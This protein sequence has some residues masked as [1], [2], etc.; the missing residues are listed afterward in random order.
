ML[1]RFS[2]ATY[3]G[4]ELPHN[5]SGNARLQSS[6]LLEPLWIAPRSGAR[7]L[8]STKEKIKKKKNTERTFTEKKKNLRT[9][10]KG[11]PLAVKAKCTS[12]SHRYHFDSLF[13]TSVTSYW[14]RTGG[15]MQLHEQRRQTINSWHRFSGGRR[16]LQRSVLTQLTPGFKERTLDIS[17]FSAQRGWISIFAVPLCTKPKN[18]QINKQL[19]KQTNSFV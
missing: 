8:I 1:S 10:G 2:V 18:K 16:S 5:S 13:I 19:N 9:R 7:D 15:K 11:P 6:Q 3:H 14:K 4:N 12:L 17:G